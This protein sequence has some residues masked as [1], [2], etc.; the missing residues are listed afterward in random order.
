MNVI[1]NSIL[2]QITAD[3]EKMFLHF[4]ERFSD[5]NILIDGMSSLH[6]NFCQ[7][8]AAARF[9]NLSTSQKY[10]LTS[11]F[12]ALR[13]QFIMGALALYRA[14]VSD[15]ANFARKAI[16]IATFAIEIYQNDESSDRWLDHARSNKSM[17]KYRS[18]FEAFQ[19]VRTHEKVLTPELVSRYEDYCLFVHP[20]YG[21]M[22]R[23]I[24]L[25]EDR[26]HLFSY[27]D[28]ENEDD[29]LYVVLKIFELL[30][31]H[32]RILVALAS[33]MQQTSSFP[34]SQWNTLISQFAEQET[35]ERMAW[36]PK[37]REFN[38]RILDTEN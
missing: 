25:T 5:S 34:T 14:H 16:E 12:Q 15:S 30:D 9:E 1:A 11:C 28:I 36:E 3:E 38:Q 23:Q 8:C 33:L 29:F 2:E 13:Y 26:R 6:E 10:A 27:F 24:E 4:K 35:I 22:Y 31:T 21:S 17:K 37:L 20:S 7:L 32:A 18:R 19:L